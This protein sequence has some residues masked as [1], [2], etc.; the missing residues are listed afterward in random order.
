MP[1]RDLAVFVRELD[2][3]RP[4]VIGSREGQGAVRVNEPVL[5]HIRGRI[6]NAVVQLLAVGGLQDTQCGFKAFRRAVAQQL[7]SRALIDGWAFDVEVLYL[8]RKMGYPIHEVGIHW[9]FDADTRVRAGS[10]TLS[11]LGEVL[12]VRWNDLRGRYVTARG[13]GVQDST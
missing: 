1:P 9:E 13:A 7:F 6:F 3:G 4:I 10:A 12:R 5:T 11:M 8:A 2:R